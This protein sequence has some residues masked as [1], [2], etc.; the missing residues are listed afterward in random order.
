MMKTVSMRTLRLPKD[1][2]TVWRMKD[3]PPVLQENNMS[4]KGKA[5]YVVPD[6]LAGSVELPGALHCEVIKGGTVY[7]L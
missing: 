1:I 3:A 6:G 4:G 5:V 2:V 7:V